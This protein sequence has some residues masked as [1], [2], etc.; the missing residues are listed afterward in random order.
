MHA[1]IR[2]QS[3]APE[4]H[5]PRRYAQALSTALDSWSMSAWT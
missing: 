5:H 2:E 4:T 1:D 3:N